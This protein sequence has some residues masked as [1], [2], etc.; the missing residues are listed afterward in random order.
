[1]S[2]IVVRPTGIK[3]PTFKELKIIGPLAKGGMGQV[4]KG[5]ISGGRLESLGHEVVVKTPIKQADPVLERRVQ[6]YFAMESF[7]TD[8]VGSNDR[9]VAPFVHGVV[10]PDERYDFEF[11][12][13]SGVEINPPFYVI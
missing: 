3:D 7:V 8:L 9:G 1:V 2:T 10:F 11:C 12:N 6:D 5:A 13:Q 4:F